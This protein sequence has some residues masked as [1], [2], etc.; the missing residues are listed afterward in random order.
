[1]DK[2]K[3]PLPYGEE[4]TVCGSDGCDGCLL[5]YKHDIDLCRE[6]RMNIGGQTMTALETLVNTG[7]HLDVY[8]NEGLGIIQITFPKWYVKDGGV[9]EGTWGGGKTIEEAAADYLGKIKNQTLVSG[10]GKDRKEIK[11]LVM[12]G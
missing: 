2:E 1:M 10:M 4:T 11:F 5:K 3:K 12:G 8:Q 9:L 7:F 6:R